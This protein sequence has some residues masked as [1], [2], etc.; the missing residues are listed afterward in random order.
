MQR[1]LLLAT[2]GWIAY[3]WGFGN[4][5]ATPWLLINVIDATNGA[6]SIVAAAAVGFVFTAVQQMASGLTAAAG[7]S[8]FERTS[9]TAWHLLR[10]RL[11]AEPRSWAEMSIVTRAVVV[12]TLGVTAV[13][14]I[15]TVVTGTDGAPRHRRTIIGASVLCGALVA[16]IGGVVGAAVWL[17][18]SVSALETST[19]WL[20]RVLGNPLFWIGILLTMLVVNR[21]T[22]T[23]ARTS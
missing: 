15:E 3:E 11:D 18:R 21:V 4:E 8:M 17:G 20:L 14:L 23:S 10:S 1:I 2:I 19:A 16:A 22:R 12:F 5:T 13:V 6:Q 9:T 7:F